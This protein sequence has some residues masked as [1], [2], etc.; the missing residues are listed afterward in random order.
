MVCF[1]NI[2]AYFARN[3]ESLITQ[4]SSRKSCSLA[5]GFVPTRSHRGGRARRVSVFG[6]DRVL[7]FVSSG[8]MIGIKSIDV[9]IGHESSVG[10]YLAKR[11]RKYRI[12]S[13]AMVSVMFVLLTVGGAPVGLVLVFAATRSEMALPSVFV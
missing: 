9:H 10:V 8:V 12:E 6:R 13:A 4:G 1:S 11:S 5:G 3:A 7:A 2:L